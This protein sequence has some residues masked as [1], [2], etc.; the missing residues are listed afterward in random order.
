MQ[1]VIAATR[2]WMEPLYSICSPGPGASCQISSQRKP[3]QPTK[4][5]GRMRW[6]WVLRERPP[7]SLQRLAVKRGAPRHQ[8]CWGSPCSPKTN[9]LAGAGKTVWL[10]MFHPSPHQ[11]WCDEHQN[12]EIG[13]AAL[14]TKSHD[15]KP[16]QTCGEW[17]SMVVTC[18]SNPIDRG[19]HLKSSIKRHS[20]GSRVKPLIHGRSAAYVSQEEEGRGRKSH[21][22]TFVTFG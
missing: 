3:H 20:L 12:P 10:K 19:I 4:W 21:K 7:A 18:Y 11:G 17:A 22:M 15:M 6:T 1:M 14:A 16:K 8:G 13:K 5:N 2:T 9:G